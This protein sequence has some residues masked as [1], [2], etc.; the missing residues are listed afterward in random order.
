MDE[1]PSE[2]EKICCAARVVV[3]AAA[4]AELSESDESEAGDSE[5]GARGVSSPLLLPAL[6]SSCFRCCR[7]GVRTMAVVALGAAAF[8]PAVARPSDGPF[9]LHAAYSLPGWTCRCTSSPLPPLYL[10]TRCCPR[11]LP[12][13]LQR[14]LRTSSW[15]RPRS[16]PA[17]TRPPAA[18]RA[19]SARASSSPWRLR[20][21]AGAHAVGWAG[22]WAGLGAGLGTLLGWA[23]WRGPEVKVGR[24]GGSSCVILG[25]QQ[26]PPARSFRPCT[27]FAPRAAQLA[28]CP[29]VCALGAGCRPSVPCLRCTPAAS[30]PT[31][32]PPPLHPPT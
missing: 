8:P 31:Y 29:L 20:R 30:P 14:R 9:L 11:F 19:A 1:E 26:R 17:A 22:G 2:L 28:A 15:R 12:A 25:N 16:T 24:A 23:G 10:L 7:S 21:P 18:T 27:S 32:T 3:E 5:A 6:P 13:C 4:D